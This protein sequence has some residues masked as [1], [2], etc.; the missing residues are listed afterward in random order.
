MGFKQ[1]V[2]LVTGTAV[3]VITVMNAGSPQVGAIDSREKMRQEAAAQSAKAGKAFEAFPQAL[4]RY[5][6][7]S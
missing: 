6:A 1:Y 3:A 7:K 2:R 5:T 4:N